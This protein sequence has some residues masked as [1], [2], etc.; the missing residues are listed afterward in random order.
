MKYPKQVGINMA[1]KCNVGC[2]YCC[3]D[4]EIME[5]KFTTLDAIKKMD[6][7]KKIKRIVLFAGLGESLVNPEFIEIVDYLY[8][9]HPE[10]LSF[11]TNG[12]ALTDKVSREISGKIS[13]INISIPAATEEYGKFVCKPLV[14][15]TIRNNLMRFKELDKNTSLT[16][17]MVLVAETISDLPNLVK[18]ANDLKVRTIN[19]CHYVANGMLPKTSSLFYHKDL[20]KSY[21]DEANK[22]SEKFGIQLNLPPLT[23]VARPRKCVEPFKIAYLTVDEYGNDIFQWC[24]AGIRWGLGYDRNNLSKKNFLALWNHPLLEWIRKTVNTEEGNILC[25]YCRNEDRFDPQYSEK[26]SKEFVDKL[27][28]LVPGVARWIKSGIFIDGVKIMEKTA[29]KNY[30]S[31]YRNFADSMTSYFRKIF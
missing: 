7:L 29:G 10:N 12:F 4:G 9:I 21:Y 26:I 6:W 19:C 30:N 16:L 15:D 27:N 11:F 20:A 28:E 23:R 31:K 17:S 3:Y 8:G 13:S 5:R 1:S 14:I 25:N 24:C 18:L 2:K 22:L